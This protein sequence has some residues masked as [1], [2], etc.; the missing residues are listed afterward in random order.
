MSIK[1]RAISP[2]RNLV[3]INSIRIEQIARLVRFET[4]GDGIVLV[5]GCLGGG[6]VAAERGVEGA[7]KELRDVSAVVWEEMR[8]RYDLPLH[9][10][11]RTW[12]L[13]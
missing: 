10:G 7:R 11:T 2:L 8:I 6:V 9:R 4:L 13:E 12:Q 1:K 3:L 5:G